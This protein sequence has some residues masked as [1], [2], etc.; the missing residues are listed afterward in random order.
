MVAAEVR[1]EQT[2]FLGICLWWGPGTGRLY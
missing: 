1:N 2:H